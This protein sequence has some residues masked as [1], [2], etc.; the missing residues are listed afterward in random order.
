[1]DTSQPDSKAKLPTDQKSHMIT[2][3]E[4]D[5]RF[6]IR[7]S[8]TEPKIKLYI[9]AQKSCEQDAYDKASAVKDAIIN[10]WL[11]ELTT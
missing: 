1:M 4:D 5:C 2:C 11:S 9:E 6:T 8:G 10:D 7:G 3:I